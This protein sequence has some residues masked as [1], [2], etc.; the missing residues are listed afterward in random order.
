MILYDLFFE[1]FQAILKF[2][3]VVI[4]FNTLVS[5]TSCYFPTI[6]VLPLA[7]IPYSTISKFIAIFSYYF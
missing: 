1:A 2:Y 5:S 4:I 7:Y 6:T 3:I